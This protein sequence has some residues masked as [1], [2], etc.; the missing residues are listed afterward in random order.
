MKT[1][2]ELQVD[3]AML[4]EDVQR[5]AEVGVTAD[6]LLVQIDQLLSLTSEVQQRLR[7]DEVIRLD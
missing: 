1:W 7:T 5:S 4:R 2:T 6:K 3:A